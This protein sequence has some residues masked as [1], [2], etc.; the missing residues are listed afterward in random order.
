MRLLD[1]CNETLDSDGSNSMAV[2]LSATI[3]WDGATGEAT[4]AAYVA[5]TPDG[6]SFLLLSLA[7]SSV[8][9]EAAGQTQRPSARCR[10]PVGGLHGV[11]R[12]C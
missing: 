10:A 11:A 6:P 4:T 12:T 3:G 5:P 7:R 1:A 8:T 2:G 9:D